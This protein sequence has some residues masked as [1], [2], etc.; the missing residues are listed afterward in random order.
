MSEPAKIA[1]RERRWRLALGADEED[2]G[3]SERDQRIDTALTALYGSGGE[4]GEKKKRGG[5]GGSS[6]RVARWL[7]DIREFFPTPVV[8]VIQ[9]DAFERLGLKRMLLEPEFLA[10]FEADVHLVADL[11]SLGATMPEKTKETA[12]QVIK[13]VVDALMERL[14]QKTSEAVRGA[15]NKQKRTSRPRTIRANLQHYQAEHETIVPERLVGFSRKTRR[16][17]MEDVILLV[18][19]SGSM[20]TSVVY[21]SIFAAVMASIPAVS[22]KFVVFD[23]AVIDLTDKLADPAEVLFG[24]QLGGGTDI[25]RALAY[26][27]DLVTRPA[28]T[29]LIMI[30]DLYEGGN[31]EEMLSR[32]EEAVQAGINVI[33]LLALSDDGRPSYDTQAAQHFASLGCPVF[34]C[35]PDQFPDMMAVALQKSDVSAWAAGQGIACV[36]GG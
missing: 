23:T 27:R 9:K 12:R 18:D 13:K 14:A 25:N 5:L 7:G 6:P 1:E 29:H 33:V 35:T 16:A 22:T 15:V 36:R 28:Q 3:L 24:A 34:A 10:S 2:G 30:T 31:R 21:S 8:Q 26:A 11:M 4:E 19:Q 20:A 17:D 32:A